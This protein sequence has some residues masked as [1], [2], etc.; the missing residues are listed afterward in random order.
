MIFG[1]GFDRSHVSSELAAR[2]TSQR[3]ERAACAFACLLVVGAVGIACG[4]RVIPYERHPDTLHYP[5]GV[6]AKVRIV[7][8]E[9]VAL[10][11]RERLFVFNASRGVLAWVDAYMDEVLA[12]LGCFDQILRGHRAP[13]G[14]HD[15]L[16]LRI[17]LAHSSGF[18]WGYELQM[19]DPVGFEIVF[20]SASH[21]A[22]LTNLHRELL[23]PGLNAMM[24]W[25]G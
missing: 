22:I 6:R 14:A 16:E 9:S 10:S 25:Y 17:F 12:D 24:D 3:L 19:V 11:K 18:G 21:G 13:R 4:P 20:H 1:S 15:A 5:T 2:R 23:N 7:R 8:A